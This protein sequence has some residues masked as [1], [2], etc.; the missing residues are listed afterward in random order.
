MI[1]AGLKRLTAAPMLVPSG[2]TWRTTAA[3]V[4]TPMPARTTRENDALA[5]PPGSAGDQSL[6]TW[7]HM[8]LPYYGT[9]S[10]RSVAEPIGALTTRDRYALVDRQPAIEDVH[11]R[12]LEPHEIGRAMSFT[13]GYTVLGTR[14]ERVR[15]YGNAVTPNASEVLLCPLVECITGQELDRYATPEPAA[16]LTGAGTA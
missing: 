8:L 11:L 12:M 5:I 16:V 14:R 6:V 7:N 15:Q 9:G 2:G 10:A 13:D 4:L 3:S 1:S